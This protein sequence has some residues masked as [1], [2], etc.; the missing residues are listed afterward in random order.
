MV[1]VVRGHAYPWDVLGDPS[2]PARARDLGLSGVTLAAAYHSVRAATPLHPRHQ[3]VDATH[4]ALYRPVRESVWSGRRLRPAAAQ[5]MDTPDPFGA[6][7]AALRHAGLPVAAWIVLTHSTRLGTA[8][9]DVAVTNCFGER[10]QYA[11]CPAHEEVR[12]YAATLAAEAVRETPLDAVSLES[13]GQLGVAHL[14]HHDKTDGAWTPTAARLLSVCCCRACQAAWRRR[15]LDPEKVLTALWAGVYAEATGAPDTEHAGPLGEID[16]AMAAVLLAARHEATDALRMRVLAAIHEQAA[17]VPVT[18]HA[19]PDP[20]VTGPSP[21]LTATAAGDVDALLVPAWPTVPATAEVVDRATA[22]GRAVDAYL[23]VLPPADPD[24]LPEHAR[25]LKAAGA[26]RFSL[27]HL[28]LA[29][30]WRQR[31]FADLIA[32]VR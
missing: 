9:P 8:H 18:L 25:R 31:L 10:Y 3:I 23:T 17:G 26:S 28:G 6:A 5:W 13:C 30:R 22:W 32:A 11:L 16:P 12:E 27:Y 29:P 24:A 20:W 1:T 2:F 4:A 21:G 7:A 15:G 19:H 14:G